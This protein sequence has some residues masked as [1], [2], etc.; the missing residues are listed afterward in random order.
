MQITDLNLEAGALKYRRDGHLI[1]VQISTGDNKGVQ[2]LSIAL[3]D[4]FSMIYPDG[5]E[6]PLQIGQLSLVSPTSN[7]SFPGSAGRPTINASFLT[8]SLYSQNVINSSSYGLHVGSA[9]LGP[10]LSLWLGGYDASRIVGPV[11]VQIVIG[12]WWVIDLLDIGIGVD[13]G[14]SP[15]PHASQYG[16]LADGNSSI[17][18]SIPVAMNPLAP[19][20]ALLDST[21]AAIAKHLPVTYQ[22]KYGLYFW[23]VDDHQYERIVSS[24]S[25]LRFTFRASG[26]PTASFEIKVPFQLLN[27]NLGPPLIEKATAYFPCQPPQDNSM[28][29]LGRAF[30]QAAFLGVDWIETPGKWYLAQAPGPNTASNAFQTDFESSV[31]S[32]SPAVS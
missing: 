5:S 27:L 17:H 2:N 32:G 24:P 28:Y 31:V 18:K 8:G 12:N 1:V 20:L 4:N 11:S 29:S 22:A 30:L 15:F 16:I 23:N 21:C 14:A 25:Y 26:L 7:Q 9:A 19:Y 13:H 6:Y 10:R 3:I